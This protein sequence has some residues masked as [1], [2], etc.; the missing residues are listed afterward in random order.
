MFH[1]I[2][3]MLSRVPGV[4]LT[5][6]QEGLA[7]EL[8]IRSGRIKPEGVTMDEQTQALYDVLIQMGEYTKS[9]IQVME[10]YTGK[11]FPTGHAITKFCPGSI[12]VLTSDSQ[13]GYIKGKTFMIQADD[14]LRDGTVRGFDPKGECGSWIPFKKTRPAT[15]EE[16]RSFVLTCPANKIKNNLKE[17]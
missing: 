16:I 12:H 15:E 13:H 7:R 2:R 17:A 10:V 1:K 11:Q 5:E 8:M 4:P 14:S 6:E 3:S 9:V